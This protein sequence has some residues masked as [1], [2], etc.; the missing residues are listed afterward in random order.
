[1][2]IRHIAVFSAAVLAGALAGSLL[3]P[4]PAQA[5]ARELIELQR[6]VTSLLQ[7]QKDL[8]TQMTQDH[9]GMR[10]IVDQTNSSLGK[11][12][13]TMGS[14]QK[15]VQ[16]VQANS[17]A[18]LDTMSTQVQGLSD[19]LEE[20][21]SRLG[22][23]NQQLVDLQNSVQSL[24]A[25]IS[26]S[27]PA[28]AAGTANPA[29][30]AVS[31]PS[32]SAAPSGPAPSADTLYSNGLRD[33]TGGKYDLARSEFQDYLKYYGDTDLASNAQFYLGEIAYSQKQFGQAVAEYE[34]VL[35]NYPKSFKLAPA[36]LKK[37]MALI[38]L[39]QK[40]SA[41]RELREV[42]KRYPGTEEDRRARA[43][44]KELGV[45]ITATR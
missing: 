34:K 28:P 40:N 9:T 17:G 20:I 13:G 42:V 38:E 43:K 12:E 35:N 18:R 29:P 30:S 44:L 36:R 33:I 26:G 45:A 1:M 3:G 21:K 27:S 19:N 15:S 16:D 4:R 7:G 25:K 23:L 22:K 32:A 6:D 37:G 5:V 10:T 8:T 24:D 41:V 11:I 39:G 2:R 31:S 14:L